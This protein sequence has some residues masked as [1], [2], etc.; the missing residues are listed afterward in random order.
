MLKI[1]V[2]DDERLIRVTIADDLREAGYIPSGNF[3]RPMLPF[4]RL[5]R[6]MPMLI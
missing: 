5:I 2:V 3:H 4:S 1:Y 6:I